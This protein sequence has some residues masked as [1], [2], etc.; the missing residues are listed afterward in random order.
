MIRERRILDALK[1][2]EIK[3]VALLDDAFDPPI[4]LDEQMGALVELLSTLPEGRIAPDVEIT[5]QQIDAVL[6]DLNKSEYSSDE[7]LSTVA[8]LFFGFVM[9]GDKKFDPGGAFEAAKAN[10]LHYVRPILQ[11]LR[12]CSPDLDIILCGSTAS[13]MDEAA[14]RAQL[15][16]VDYFLNANLSPDG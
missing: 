10:N 4:L 5:R 1:E 7:V 16:F 2:S 15:I 6:A 8:K 13:N 14:K 3:C 11:L 9:T 12:K